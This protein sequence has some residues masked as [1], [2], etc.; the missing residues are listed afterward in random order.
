[1][2]CPDKFLRHALFGLSIAVL[3]V[4]L[5]FPPAV[6]D[7]ANGITDVTPQQTIEPVTLAPPMASAYASSRKSGKR[8]FIEFRS[9]SAASYGHMYVLYGRLSERGQIVS[10][11]IAGLHPAGDTNDCINCSVYPWTI[12]HL[13]FVPAETNASDGDLE[14]KYV[15]SRFRVVLDKAQYD[16]ISAYIRKLQANNQLWHA[17]LRN[18]VSFGK[19]I[20]DYMG[21]RTPV[22]SLVEPKDFVDGLRELNGVRPQKALNDAS[23]GA[24]ITIRATPQTPAPDAKPPSVPKKPAV[25]PALISRAGTAG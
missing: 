4:G 23:H 14:E 24:Q 1:M 12:G 25:D 13:I 21:L 16:R 9:R 3:S 7:D 22:F 18:C 5:S 10:S 8:Y 20:A 11:K 17:L 19:D 15:T 6:A 2:R